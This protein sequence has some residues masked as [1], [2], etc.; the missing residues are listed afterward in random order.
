MT[1]SV[2]PNNY[3][4]IATP[5]GEVRG[6]HE[7]G[8]LQF[9]GI[10]YANAR[11]WEDP[12][13]VT[14]WEGVY[15]ATRQG[16]YCPQHGYFHPE[17]PPEFNGFYDNQIISNPAI[18]FSEED[19][20]NVNIWAPEDGE[21]HPVA[22][23]IHGGSFISGGNGNVNICNG[24]DYCKR[25][26]VLVS[27]NYRL[28]AFATGRDKTHGG[29]YGL[30]DQ[31]AA[32]TWVRDNIAAFGGDPNHVTVMGESAG[33]Q[34][35][36]MLLYCPYAKGLFH[37]AVMMSG[38]GSWER[39]YWPGRP[40]ACEAE[41]E[42]VLEHFGV[43][44]LDDLKKVPAKEI[45]DAWLDATAKTPTPTLIGPCHIIDGDWIPG[46]LTELALTNS[47]IDV[48][49]ITGLSTDD[50]WPYFLYN[51]AIEWGAYHSRAGRQPVYGYYFTRDTGD[52]DEGAY[53]GIDLWYAFNTLHRCRR[54]FNE[55]DQ[56]IA[57]NMIDYFAAF[58][59]TGVPNVEGLAKWEPLTDKETKFIEFGDELPAMVQPPVNKLATSIRNTTKPFPGEGR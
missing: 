42:L 37:S 46:T 27:I 32:L 7:D 45:Y 18:E 13:I 40:G 53:H 36:Q 9:S 4:I 52:D 55:I 17:D 5:C 43:D 39:F 11:R 50:I 26:I 15:D 34:S 21:N 57:E 1:V 31:V 2:E 20:L 25:G 47:V 10:K 12:V 29:N 58:I 3:V 30:R 22:V 49:C 35:V 16:P 28:N 48:P 14:G 23:F 56:R 19:C 54:S 44:S 41:W 33:A 24:A 38:A 8:F 59:K 51:A 6:V